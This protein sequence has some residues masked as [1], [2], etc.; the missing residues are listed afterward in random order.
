MFACRISHMSSKLIIEPNCE[1]ISKEAQFSLSL[2]LV[3]P[4]LAYLLVIVVAGKTNKLLDGCVGCRLRC[5]ASKKFDVGERK[6]GAAPLVSPCA[7][8]TKFYGEAWQNLCRSA[9]K[10]FR[11]FP[12]T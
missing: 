11:A 4:S 7:F 12:L 10:K 9:Q 2:S 6:V 8:G 1:R 5:S 3:C